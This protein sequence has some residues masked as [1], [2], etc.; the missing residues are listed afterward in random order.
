MFL[1]WKIKKISAH[2]SAKYPNLQGMVKFYRTYGDTRVTAYICG[3]TD[4]SGKP[5]QS[6]HGFHIHEGKQCIEGTKE[7]F[8]STGAHWN[9]QNAAHPEHKGDLPP[10]LANDG[11]AWMQV[12]TGRFF[13]EEVVGHTV[14]IHDMPDDFHTQPS[15]GS[16]EKIA[17]GEILAGDI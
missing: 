6:F 9:P 17:C 12:F 15:G 8:A 3:I 7:P 16:G 5:S 11:V 14:I 2:F 1:L 13:P 10:L 4:A